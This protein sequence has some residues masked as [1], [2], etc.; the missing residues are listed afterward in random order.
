MK[1]P[2]ITRITLKQVRHRKGR[3]DWQRVDAMTDA[4]VIAAAKSDLDA[5]PMT[6]R[7]LAKFKRVVDPKAVREATGLSQW[8]FARAFRLPIGTVRD[9]EQ[10]RSRPDQAARNYLRVIAN[11]PMAAKRAVAAN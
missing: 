2:R 5:P 10:G 4:E 9:W 3:S 8:A 11:D 7:Q 1:K 6:K